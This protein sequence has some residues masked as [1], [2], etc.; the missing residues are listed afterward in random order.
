MD[1]RRYTDTFS[2]VCA[3]SISGGMPMELVTLVEWRRK[4]KE[5]EKRERAGAGS[6]EVVVGRRVGGYLIS[7]VA[8]RISNQL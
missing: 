3:Y 2:L 1:T 8:N 7:S 5:E 6:S 4:G